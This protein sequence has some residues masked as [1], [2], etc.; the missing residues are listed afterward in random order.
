LVWA[1]VFEK[2]RRVVLSAGMIT[3]R[4]RIQ[5]EGDV[6][7][8]VAHH[9]IDLSTELGSVAIVRNPSRCHTAEATNSTMAARH[10]IR[11]AWRP[12]ACVDATSTSR[13]LTSTRSA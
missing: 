12:G 11:A 5:R 1:K 13:N 9:L 4:G 8:L 2:Y 3:V 10:P 7:D 6:V